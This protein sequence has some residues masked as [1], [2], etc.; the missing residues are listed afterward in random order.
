MRQEFDDTE[1]R[2]LREMLAM[3]QESYKKEAKPYIDRLAAIHATRLPAPMIVTC[4]DHL[5]APHG[6][7]RTASHS[8]GRYVCECEGWEP[9]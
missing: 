7:D 9:P 2:Y 5:D 8:L 4:S 1:E 3:L 6:F